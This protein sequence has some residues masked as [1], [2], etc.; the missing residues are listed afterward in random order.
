MIF[1]IYIVIL[2]IIYHHYQFKIKKHIYILNNFN[3]III[4]SLMIIFVKKNII[5][6]KICILYILLLC[7]EL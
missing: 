1:V 5:I 2:N 4:L 3:K 7:E 6:I